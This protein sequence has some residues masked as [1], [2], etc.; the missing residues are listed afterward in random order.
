MRTKRHSRAIT[1]SS[2]RSQGGYVLA[3]ILGL[4]IL[5]TLL[6]LA[7]LAVSQSTIRIEQTGRVRERQTRA[8]EAAVEVAI[9][10]V[11]NSTTIATA[12]PIRRKS[13]ADSGYLAGLPD[14]EQLPK[15][16]NDVG[17]A[18]DRDPLVN[19]A[20]AG[21][22][23]DPVDKLI[24]VDGVPVRIFCYPQ[25]LSEY[26]P[27]GGPPLPG[28][29]QDNGAIAVRLVGDPK[30]GNNV[31]VG[32]K[33]NPTFVDV[34]ADWRTTFPFKAA[35]T[36]GYDVGEI[37]GTK[38]QLLYRGYTPLKIVG[39]VQI[40][41]QIAAVSPSI[42]GPA[43]DVQG[44]VEQG[45]KGMFD[46][47]SGALDCGIARS[48][49]AMGSPGA[50]V[51]VDSLF[52]PVAQ[53]LKCNQPAMSALSDIGTVPPDGEWD[54]DRV[55]RNRYNTDWLD[56]DLKPGSPGRSDNDEVPLDCDD[57]KGAD[58][59]PSPII[60]IEPGAYDARATK[61]L[62]AMFIGCDNRTWY[63]PGGNYWF[64]VNDPDLPDS[65][66]AKS[67]LV[68]SNRTSSWVFGPM[69][70]FDDPLVA[71]DFFPDGRPRPRAFPDHVCN[72]GNPTGS[73]TSSG[74]SITLSSR[75]GIYHGNVLTYPGGSPKSPGAG[76]VVICGPIVVS[77]VQS[78][79]IHQRP[80]NSLG[81]RLLPTDVEAGSFSLTPNPGAVPSTVLLSDDGDQL[82]A[83]QFVPPSWWDSGEG[84]FTKSFTAKAFGVGGPNGA[85]PGPSPVSSVYVDITGTGDSVSNPARDLTSTKLELWLAGNSSSSPNCSMTYGPAASDTRRLPGNNSTVSYD[86]LDSAA[87]GNCNSV[88]SGTTTRDQFYGAKVKA[89]FTLNPPKKAN[90]K[91]SAIDPWTS[92]W[93]WLNDAIKDMLN[94]ICPAWNGWS[95]WD[96]LNN[97][98][99]TRQ[100]WYWQCDD[101]PPEVSYSVNSM[102]LRLGWTPEV[103][104]PVD[105]LGAPMPPNGIMV[106]NAA[107]AARVNADGTP[108]TAS[109]SVSMPAGFGSSNSYSKFRYD[110]SDPAL[111]D[112]FLPLQG[113]D[114]NFKMTRTGFT[115]FSG[116]DDNDSNVVQFTLKTPDGV[117]CR[118]TA[119]LVAANG[120]VSTAGL[121]YVGNDG[122]YKQATLRPTAGVVRYLPGSREVLQ[123][124][125]RPANPV[126]GP[127]TLA[128]GGTNEVKDVDVAQIVSHFDDP[129][130]TDPTHKV[131]ATLDV[132]ILMSNRSTAKNVTVDWV[133]ISATAGVQKGSSVVGYPRPEDPITVT[134]SP[135]TANDD[136]DGDGDVHDGDA[137]Y[138]DGSFNV[139]GSVSVPDNDV[140]VIWN[141]DKSRYAGPLGF[142]IFNS[143]RQE[144]QQCSPSHPEQCR[145]ALVASA[146]G[147]WAT[148]TNGGYA[149][150]DNP[151]TPLVDEAAWPALDP[152]QEPDALAST[153]NYRK[154]IRNVRIHA[155]VVDPPGSGT[156][157]RLLPRAEATVQ[158]ADRLQSADGRWRSIVPG[159]NV[160][161][162]RWKA[163]RDGPY[164][165]GSNADTNECDTPGS[166]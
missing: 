6:V 56:N 136:G 66:P 80:A 50:D 127:M 101:R 81:A 8:A 52:V 107:D 62:N 43:L 85:N 105:A 1:S 113:V 55:Q 78:T 83:K 39:G 31:Y 124:C 141:Y 58:G 26:L 160:W 70:R 23:C 145:P 133:T 148:T 156:N 11:R 60:T 154:P 32:D 116:A 132:E 90:T 162:T 152:G 59:F 144:Y 3:T 89:T 7:M 84:T 142:P 157:G 9:N 21:G 51:R 96:W 118:T 135:V 91:W 76:H 2:G 65:N 42:S 143:G 87:S 129:V 18:A 12:D 72:R 95:V 67:S 64:D 75:T 33:S 122:Y 22:A 86:L 44:V 111:L 149:V 165:P 110:I 57:F 134:W 158:I 25:E 53:G 102:A 20:A 24:E 5:S 73:N 119:R 155:C 161:I 126:A 10:Q 159:A 146:L 48:D 45:G 140:R 38:G 164:Q 93:P 151:G 19:R 147:S 77:G 106:V 35:M 108:N 103:S 100:D 131:K 123:G 97:T 36:S 98:F 15:D 130:T 163:L 28:I 79:A 41:N 40:K 139:W 37:S 17:W 121:S 71:G 54:N 27:T 74:T 92:W 112:G 69:F 99:G 4:L 16:R 14:H 68:F 120:T 61:R 63:F 166:G 13:P 109:A 34:A 94:T 114:F 117:W 30:A 46:A 115:G 82:T 104:V 125:V 29:P 137:G 47:G 49:D 138:G 128:P 153:G 88:L 150:N